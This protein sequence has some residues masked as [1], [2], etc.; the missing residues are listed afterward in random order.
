MLSWV[1]C[2]F[3]RSEAIGSSPPPLPFLDAMLC[4]WSS[5]PH[6]GESWRCGQCSRGLESEPSQWANTAGI[7]NATIKC[8]FLNFTCS[9]FFTKKTHLWLQR[10]AAFLCHFGLL[11][12][13]KKLFEDVTLSNCDVLISQF[14]WH[15]TENNGVCACACV[16]AGCFMLATV[17]W[18]WIVWPVRAGSST[19]SRCVCWIPSQEYWGQLTYPSTLPSGWYTDRKT[20]TYILTSKIM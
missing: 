8:R 12:I 17:W 2:R 14:H 3:Q 4:S 5:T 15:L 7:N 10:F 11:V 13:Q 1:G 6:A 16:L 18:G 9:W 19:P 20:H